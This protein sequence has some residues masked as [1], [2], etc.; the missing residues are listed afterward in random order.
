MPWS[1]LVRGNEI[2]LVMPD[3]Y[4][5]TIEILVLCTANQCRSPMAEAILRDHLGRR[6]IG[7]SV[8]SAGELRGGVAA[9]DG[10]VR[11]MRQRGSDI[12]AHVST[13]VTPELIAGADLVLAMA[14]RHLRAAVAARPDAF[15]RTFTLKELVRRGATI[16]KRAPDEP[17]ESWLA[18]VHD[19]RTTATLLGDDEADDVADPMG[20]TDAQ[21]LSTAAELD[22]LVTDLVDLAF[23]HPSTTEPE[24]R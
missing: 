8:R 2:G 7:A 12:A 24:T 22:E 6:G 10:A 13:S 21:Y 15:G 16:G 9:S 5:P 23:P 1:Q 4:T 3:S 17:L 14:R 19:G 18:S 20:G 11:A